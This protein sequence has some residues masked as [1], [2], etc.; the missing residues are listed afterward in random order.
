VV[1]LFTLC[2]GQLLLQRRAKH[3]IS[4]TSNSRVVVTRKSQCFS[5]K[6]KSPPPSQSQSVS[7]HSSCHAKHELLQSNP[8]TVV[9]CSLALFLS[10]LFLQQRSVHEIQLAYRP[11]I[12]RQIESFSSSIVQSRYAVAT[13]A[14][15]ADEGEQTVVNVDLAG[16]A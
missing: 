12:A 9:V 4:F 16:Q 1:A 2:H 3:V 11:H 6:P 10:G 14:P 15:F 13:P 7:S 5:H 8:P